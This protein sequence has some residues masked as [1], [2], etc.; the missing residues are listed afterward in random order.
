MTHCLSL[1]ATLCDHWSPINKF[2]PNAPTNNEN[3]QRLSARARVCVWIFGAVL[4]KWKNRLKTINDVEAVDLEAISY[5]GHFFASA[6]LRLRTLSVLLRMLRGRSDPTCLKTEY[7]PVY[8]IVYQPLLILF[9]LTLSRFF[10]FKYN[11]GVSS[12][13]TIAT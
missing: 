12:R 1:A 8:F 7:K 9:F 6:A 2:R 5:Y 3:I 10:L 11:V 13:H 4:Q